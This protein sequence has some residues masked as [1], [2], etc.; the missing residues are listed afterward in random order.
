MNT[1]DKNMTASHPPAAIEH[2]LDQ[3]ELQN[4]ADFEAVSVRL[5]AVS[6]VAAT[7][8]QTADE[9]KKE[10]NDTRVDVADRIAA[11]RAERGSTLYTGIF[12]L[13]GAV[14]AMV[15]GAAIWTNI[16]QSNTRSDITALS[17]KVESQNTA[18][19]SKV[20]TQNALV[21]AQLGQIQVALTKLEDKKP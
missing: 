16:S 10:A 18:M 5:D 8:K 15:G 1:K 14:A 6:G 11:V 9:A 2:R 13:I 7:A 19:N 20:D 21:M 12:G 4:R 3:H 17:A